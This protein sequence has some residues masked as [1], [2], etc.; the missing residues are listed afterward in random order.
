MKHL[1][2]VNTDT[3][4][5]FKDY[6]VLYYVQDSGKSYIK[7]YYENPFIKIFMNDSYHDTSIIPLIARKYGIISGDIEWSHNLG[8]IAKIEDGVI[9]FM[10]HYTGEITVTATAGGKTASHTA[11]IECV[12][13][14]T[15]YKYSIINV[16]SPTANWNDEQATIN[17]TY[18]VIEHY[19]LKQSVTTDTPQSVTVTFPRN[20]HEFNYATSNKYVDLGLSTGLK[21]AACSIGT[22]NE[23]EH[24]LFFQWGDTEG[25]YTPNKDASV[26]RTGTFDFE[27]VEGTPWTVTQQGFQKVFDWAHYKYCNGSSTTMTKYCT[28]SDYGTEDNKTTLEPEDDAA[29]QN[30]RLQSGHEE[31]R[32]PTATE[33][34]TLYNET[35]WVWCP[36]GNVGIKKTDE[37][38]NESIEYIV[39]PSGYFVFKTE[40]DKKQRGT[41]TKDENGNLIGYTGTNG[42]IYYPGAHKVTKGNVTSIA[43]GDIHIFFPVSGNANGTGVYIRGSYGYYWSSSLHPSFS[44]YGLNLN[45]NSGGVNPQNLNN[46]C[47]GFCV[48]S[49]LE[50]LS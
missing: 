28:S 26:T 17:F 49:V 24:G 44:D 16:S 20:E 6:D 1:L 25:F 37:S 10:E 3:E 8:N 43:D 36:G 41:F 33:Y 18:R 27:S 2:N 30:L 29:I 23:Y 19:P 47:L 39:Y 50:N 11:T 46:R 31:A 34:Q 35:L 13:L 42:T 32:M 14:P 48:R 9:R 15:S 12:E 4:T 7:K 40:S 21:W 38:G 22:Q 5:T 45:F